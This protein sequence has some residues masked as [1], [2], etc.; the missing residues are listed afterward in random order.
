MGKNTIVYSTNPDWRETCPVCD[1]PADEC[2]CQPNNILKEK[3]NTIYLKREVKGR[4]GKTVTSISN[5]SGDMKAMQKEIQRWC[6]AGGTTKNGVIEI[7][8]DHRARIKEY[9]EK[10]GFRVK[11]A[12][13]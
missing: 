3:S 7:Q 6:G 5:M 11:L 13:G 4:G 9:L 12:G 8:G 10:Q 2:T 1:L